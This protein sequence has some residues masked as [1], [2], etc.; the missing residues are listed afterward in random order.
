[1]SCVRRILG[2]H[3]VAALNRDVAVDRLLIADRVYSSVKLTFGRNV[4]ICEIAT[5]GTHS[6]QNRIVWAIS[7]SRLLSYHN[8]ATAFCSAN[9][10]D[11]AAVSINLPDLSSRDVTDLTTRVADTEAFT[12]TFKI[13]RD[14]LASRM[15]DLH[16]RRGLEDALWLL[17]HL[18]SR[19]DEFSLCIGLRLVRGPSGKPRPIDWFTFND[20][21]K[22]DAV[23][24]SMELSRSAL[25]FEI[26]S[27][28]ALGFDYCGLETSWYDDTWSR[29]SNG[30]NIYADFDTCTSAFWDELVNY[31]D[32]GESDT[33]APE[34]DGCLTTDRLTPPV[35]KRVLVSAKSIN[36][37]TVSSNMSSLQTESYSSSDG[38]VS[39]GLDIPM[40]ALFRLPSWS[41]TYELTITSRFDDRSGE[42]IFI[43]APP[44]L[45]IGAIGPHQ[46][47]IRAGSDTTTVPFEL[48]VG[49]LYNVKIL[50]VAVGAIFILVDDQYAGVSFIDKRLL[51]LCQ[52]NLTLRSTDDSPVAFTVSNMQFFDSAYYPSSSAM[53]GNATES[54]TSTESTAAEVHSATATAASAEIGSVGEVSDSH[55]PGEAT[56][57][58][59]VIVD[60]DLPLLSNPSAKDHPGFA[61]LLFVPVAIFSFLSVCL[62]VIIKCWLKSR[63]LS[64]DP[65]TTLTGTVSP[66][67]DLEA[68]EPAFEA[69]KEVDLTDYNELCAILRMRLEL[70]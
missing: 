41:I 52:G 29:F 17:D 4:P 59:S 11:M 50:S 58:P 8:N 16:D 26:A 37:V 2:L 67:D 48:E 57:N 64:N 46:I 49:K 14:I 22:F 55:F 7:N 18:K 3:V 34:V 65:E 25:K 32:R 60:K 9:H 23:G 44:H 31:V 27:M 24:L 15:S 12:S 68:A 21:S 47:S 20:L 10:C 6:C 63:R 62:G 42:A 51:R 43:E 70:V 53:T 13:I 30:F 54:T 56:T 45:Q 1:M 61:W 39:L 40:T 35:V 38:E 28:F 5:S 36:G 69:T 19:L 33:P 66:H